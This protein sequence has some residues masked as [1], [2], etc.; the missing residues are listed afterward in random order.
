MNSIS[1]CVDNIFFKSWLYLKVPN[2]MSLILSFFVSKLV[3][4][5]L[6][7]AIYN[8]QIAILKINLKT[9]HFEI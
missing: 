9:L 2:M 8:S 1:I 4:N 6:L 7:V 3:T 5:I